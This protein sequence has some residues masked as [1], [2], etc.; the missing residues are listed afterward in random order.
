MSHIT[1]TSR[2]IA[3][4]SSVSIMP[5]AQ[6]RRRIRSL[7]NPAT[8]P[9]EVD[10]GLA[11]AE[12]AGC[13]QRRGPR[14]F[15]APEKEAIRRILSLFSRESPP[16]ADLLSRRVGDFLKDCAAAG[17]SPAAAAHLVVLAAQRLAW[18]GATAG[19]GATLRGARALLARRPRTVGGDDSGW[20]RPSVRHREQAQ[21]LLARK[22]VVKIE[23]VHPDDRSAWL[24]LD[25]P[26]AA[27]HHGGMMMSR[28]CALFYGRTAREVRQA[29]GWTDRESSPSRAAARKATEEIG[30]LLG[31]PRCCRR[32]YA[33][34][35]Q[36][37]QRR[38]FWRHVANRIAAPGA[39]PW[40]LN[41]AGNTAADHVPCSLRCAPS[42][43]Q[44]RRRLARGR[45]AWMP[46]LRNPCLLLWDVGWSWV[47]LRP[48][49][50][51][52]ERF[53]Y[54]PGAHFPEGPDIDA[55]LAGDEIRLERETLLVLKRGRPYASLSGRA[56]LWWHE[57]AFQADF[58]RSLI[59][60]RTA[61]PDAPQ[62]PRAQ[63]RA[64]TRALRRLLA[65]VD[66]ELR[67]RGIPCLSRYDEGLLR[68]RLAG[69]SFELFMAPRS[70]YRG[71]SFETLPSFQVCVRG[72]LRMTPARERSLRGYL[73]EL[74]RRDEDLKSALRPRPS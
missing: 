59:A 65:G 70:T 49:T 6:A 68:L 43:A 57:K 27:I 73:R 67:R 46:E 47:E 4:L 39:V 21:A 44:A 38:Y 66:G 25:L 35:P 26:N 53:R 37:I 60:L 11:V 42:L 74:A 48:Q 32:A 1:F 50:P 55:V 3:M 71:P 58:W 69:Q 23:P 30:R 13:D 61:A 19:A 40:E 18:K 17:L 2:L 9:E 41:P 7:A 52:S 15:Q 72:K 12:L 10:L 22:P 45:E 28:P 51:P 33:Q 56:F 63:P 20:V 64:E 16:P 5:H 14:R 62:A 34:A 8:R 36:P 24:A 31:Y 29:I 54:S